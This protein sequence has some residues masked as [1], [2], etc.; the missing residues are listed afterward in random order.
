MSSQWLVGSTYGGIA[1]CFRAQVEVYE[2]NLEFH[3]KFDLNFLKFCNP[4]SGSLLLCVR[5]GA[6]W[7]GGRATTFLRENFDQPMIQHSCHNVV[8]VWDLIH[9]LVS[10]AFSNILSTHRWENHCLFATHKSSSVL[11]SLIT[12]FQPSRVLC[13]PVRSVVSAENFAVLFTKQLERTQKKDNS[14]PLLQWGKGGWHKM[15]GRSK[16]LSFESILTGEVDNQAER[17]TNTWLISRK[18]TQLN[19]GTSHG[20]GHDARTLTLKKIILVISWSALKSKSIY[21]QKC[22]TSLKW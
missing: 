8:I 17:L 5:Y 11:D 2:L 15:I 16:N 6:Q 4:T 10:A 9:H 1:V 19:Q 12:D 13:E 21:Q 22:L 14:R 3:K 18:V 20:R 7:Q